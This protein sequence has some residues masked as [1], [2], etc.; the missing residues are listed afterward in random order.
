MSD[1]TKG[2]ALDEPEQAPRRDFLTKA[3]M[4][5]TAGT[6]AFAAIGIIRMPKPGVMP[7]RSAAVKIGTPGEFPVSDQP[8]AVAGRNMFILHQDDGFCAISAVCTHLGC[9]VAPSPTGFNC[10][11]H[12]SKFGKDGSLIQG[13]AGSPLVWFE[14]SQAPD[15]QLVVHTDRSVKVGTRYKFA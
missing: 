14:I 13:P 1:E 5:V 11:C 15:G 10:P 8:I 3:A 2:L 4:T 9:V 7:G 12:G 6:V